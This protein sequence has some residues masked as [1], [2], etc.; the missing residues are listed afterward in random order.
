MELIMKLDE[1]IVWSQLKLPGLV[2]HLI[3]FKRSCKLVNLRTVKAAALTLWIF[4]Q[5]KFEDQNE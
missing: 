5:S 2:D 3:A 1:L 4:T